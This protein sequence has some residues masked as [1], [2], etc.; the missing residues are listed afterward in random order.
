MPPKRR[1]KSGKTLFNFQQ[2][3]TGYA[4]SLAELLLVIADRPILIGFESWIDMSMYLV[5][6]LV[7]S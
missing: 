7:F 3:R 1:Q 5:V 4:I 2:Q 6:M